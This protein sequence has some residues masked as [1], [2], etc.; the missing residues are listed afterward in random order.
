[1]A[2]IRPWGGKA[3]RLDDSV[4]V[5]EGAVVLGDVEIG[6]RS[7]V[8]FGAVLRG[9]VNHIRI[10]A[11]TNLQD[12]TVVH[13]TSHTHPTLVGDDVTLGHRVTLHGCTVKDRCLI[14]I[15]AVVM[16]GAQIGEDAMVG[17]G[18]LVPPGMVVPPR[19][20]ALG[21][22]ARLKRELTQKEVDY[23]RASAANYAAYAEQYR[24]EG[25]LSR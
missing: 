3:P 7:S 6:P 9:D 11:R 18:S 1:M 19:T 17:A 14:G 25:W 5:A 13:V 10:G 16:D 23:F 2:L 22:P 20:L 21:S 8:W 12:Y 15:G 24:R 4:W